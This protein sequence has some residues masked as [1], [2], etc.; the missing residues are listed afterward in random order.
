MDLLLQ[1]HES[2]GQCTNT[3][4]VLFWIFLWKCKKFSYFLFMLLT[5]IVKNLGLYVTSTM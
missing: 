1:E 3:R 2:Q 5:T 4:S